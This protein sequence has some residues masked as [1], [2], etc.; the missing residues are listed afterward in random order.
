ML[1]YF[2]GVTLL[3]NEKTVVKI[4]TDVKVLLY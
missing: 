4:Y 1:L 3:A 2:A